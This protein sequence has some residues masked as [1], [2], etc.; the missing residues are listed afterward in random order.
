VFKS[1][2]CKKLNQED[3]NDLNTSITTN[4]IETVIKS[5]PS[6]KSPGPHGFTAAFY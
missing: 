5:L 4:D 3:L 1:Q 6:K 2:Y